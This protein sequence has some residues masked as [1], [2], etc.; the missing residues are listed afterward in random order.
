VREDK[1]PRLTA[2]LKFTLMTLA[3]FHWDKNPEKG[4]NVTNRRLAETMCV[5]VRTVRRHL[6]A[7]VKIGKILIEDHPHPK[8][9][10]KIFVLS[11]GTP[12]SVEPQSKGH[13]CPLPRDTSVRSLNQVEEHQV[14]E[15][16]Q[17]PKGGG[18]RPPGGDVRAVGKIEP[19]EP[20]PRARA[21]LLRPNTRDWV[22]NAWAREAHLVG[23]RRW[24]VGHLDR[25]LSQLSQQYSWDQVGD[26]I[27]TFFARYEQDIRAKREVE[28]VRMFDQQLKQ[29]LEEIAEIDTGYI[30]TGYDEDEK[31]KM[32]RSANEV[33]RQ[34]VQR[35]G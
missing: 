12:V 19:D 23:R 27:E 17:A 15:E 9:R 16:H 14:L 18:L 20:E 6:T 32:F 8:R 3:S 30:D 34:H 22:K 4:T 7:L 11:Q 13:Q 35:T 26:L 5:D 29:S 24:N 31:P 25:L 33:M 21:N 10:G 28:L 2:P 1:D